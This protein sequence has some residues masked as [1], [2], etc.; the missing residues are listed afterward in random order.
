MD[1]EE[2]KKELDLPKTSWIEE[3]WLGFTTWIEIHWKI[4]INKLNK[5]E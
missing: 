4:F 2:L 1:I 5:Q 3:K